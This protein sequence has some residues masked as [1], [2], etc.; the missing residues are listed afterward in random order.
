M[1]RKIMM[2]MLA[3]TVFAACGGENPNRDYS[4]D[5]TAGNNSTVSGLPDSPNAGAVYKSDTVRH[6]SAQRHPSKPL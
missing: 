4:K 5:S 6:D 3:C 2:A 1:Y